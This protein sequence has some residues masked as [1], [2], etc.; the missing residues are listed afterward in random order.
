V[1]YEI[2]GQPIFTVGRAHLITQA[3]AACGGRNVF[4]ALEL[5]APQVSVEAVIAAAPQLIVAGADRA[6]RP[7][8]L[9]DW[10]RWPQIPA[11]RDGNLAVVDADKLHRPA[12]RFVDG[13]ADLCAA[14]D[15]ARSAE[16]GR[17]R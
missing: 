6:E 11:V 16:R 3:I 9:D 17:A 12:P 5:P 8:W 10:T 7:R 13:M 15:R 4:D 14:I 2:W 1:F